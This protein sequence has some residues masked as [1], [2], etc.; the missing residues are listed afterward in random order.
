MQDDDGGK[1]EMFTFVGQWFNGGLV[2]G[3]GRG[4]VTN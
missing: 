2:T 3:S 4:E 1:G